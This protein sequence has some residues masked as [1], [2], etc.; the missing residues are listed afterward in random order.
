[1]AEFGSELICVGVAGAQADAE[2]KAEVIEDVQGPLPG[3]A[4]RVEIAGGA[5]CVAEVV[6][7]GGLRLALADF[8]LTSTGKVDRMALQRLVVG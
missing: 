3:V 2:G 6:E 7:S 5:V 4:G 1:M 8:P